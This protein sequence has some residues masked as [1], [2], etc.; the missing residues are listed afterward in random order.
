[1]DCFL[2]AIYADA[3]RIVMS[4]LSSRS[5][6]S[7]EAAVSPASID[8]LGDR[9]LGHCSEL[10]IE[11]QCFGVPGEPD[12]EIVGDFELNGMISGPVALTTILDLLLYTKNKRPT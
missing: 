6:R 7:R 4:R 11:L 12:S 10:K 5:S 3:E 9:L 2:S 8:R 1:M